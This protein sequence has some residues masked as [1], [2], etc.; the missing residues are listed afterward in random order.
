[1][2]ILTGGH[3]EDLLAH[4]GAGEFGGAVAVARCQLHSVGHIELLRKMGPAEIS[5]ALRLNLGA[6][7]TRGNY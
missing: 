6:E 7:L 1:M 3:K 5:E 2:G 4:N